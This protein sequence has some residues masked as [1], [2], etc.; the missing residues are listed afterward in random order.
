MA[1]APLIISSS[2][3]YFNSIENSSIP[4]RAKINMNKNRRAAYQTR[5]LRLA[6]VYPRILARAPQSLASFSTRKSLI[7]LKAFK[8]SPAEPIFSGGIDFAIVQSIKLIVTTT[9]SNLFQGSFT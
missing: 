1:V 4:R 8:A 3:S 7:A 9:A 2:A 5:S 6:I